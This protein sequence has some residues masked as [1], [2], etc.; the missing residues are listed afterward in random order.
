MTWNASQDQIQPVTVYALQRTTI[1]YTSSHQFAAALE[2]FPQL[3][4]AINVN[5][6]CTAGLPSSD[7]LAHADDPHGVAAARAASV[8]PRSLG[9]G[10][11]I[12]VQLR[13]IPFFADV[14]ELKLQ[15]LAKLCEV[16]PRAD[17]RDSSDASAERHW[18]SFAARRS[19]SPLWD[20]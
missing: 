3:S 14:E 2:Q 9:I 17:R 15:Q 5:P 8:G 13:R 4:V 6:D 16:R 19:P 18:L 10:A 1:L 7:S 12:Q 20:R 11:P